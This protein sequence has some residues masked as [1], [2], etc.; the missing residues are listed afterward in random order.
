MKQHIRQMIIL[1][2]LLAS[3]SAAWGYNIKVANNPGNVSV[4]ATAEANDVVTLTITAPESKYI[5]P[6]DI[7]IVKKATGGM[8]QA[9]H[10]TPGLAE[11]VMVK[12]AEVDAHGNGTYTFVMP[13]THVEITTAFTDLIDFSTAN[14]DITV[15][16]IA[17]QVYTG[18]A[19]TPTLTVKDG[20]TELT[21]GTHYTITGYDN[22]INVGTATIHLSSKST[23][24]YKG[25]RDVTFT[26]VPKA[27]S[28][29]AITN[30][31]EEYEWA[32][33]VKP[34]PII[35][36][37]NTTLMEGQD[38]DV[39]YTNNTD[40]TKNAQLTVTYKG[41]YSGQASR[42]FAIVMTRNDQNEATTEGNTIVIKENDEGEI[43]AVVTEA[44]EDEDGNVSIPETVKDANG[45][46]YPVTT[47]GAN[48]FDGVSGVEDIYLESHQELTI[49]D[50]TFGG[51]TT[52]GAKVHVY[53]TLLDGYAEGQ[54]SAL[55][56]NGQL[57]TDITNV[58]HFFTFSNAHNVLLP[59]GVSQYICK[60]ID[61]KVNIF[62][63]EGNIIKANT[64]VL[65]DGAPKTYEFVATNEAC[66]ANYDGNSLVA[67]T[68]GHSID[69]VAGAYLLKHNEFWKM[70]ATGSM[71]D[72]K[73]YLLWPGSVASA[74][75][76]M[77]IISNTTGIS[78]VSADRTNSGDAY[79]ITGQKVSGTYKGIVI[80]N[81]KKMVVK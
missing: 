19:I 64:G 22:N 20:G 62:G 23:C 52:S 2:V 14:A 53:Q 35:K 77:A 16:A 55:V 38:Y 70:G 37:G 69:D 34:Q 67:V 4:A 9:P 17:D 51:N 36:D 25:S 75:A 31:N 74:P 39:S 21:E 49:E 44:K 47:I 78:T 73:A 33:E 24:L 81:G 43:V 61:D 59:E 5:T 6:A 32:S 1:A 79:S 60:V 18:A 42:T 65:L 41:N 80:K 7:L 50:A 54:L 29:F 71:P 76:R 26:I 10:R 15:S 72:G 30:I 13:T 27:A 12:A 66:M 57:V 46:D 28:D 3:G 40:V 58:A 48:A 68:N 45:N 8:A 63:V 56:D 11:P